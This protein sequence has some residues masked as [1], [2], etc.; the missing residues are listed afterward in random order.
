MLATQTPGGSTEDELTEMLV[1]RGVAGIIFV[2]G[3]HADTTADMQRYEQLRGQGVP[4]RPR[5]RLL[6]EG[7]GARSSPPT[8]GRRCA[9]PSR[10]WC[11]WATRRIGLALGP[12]RFVP[13][14]RKIEGFLRT[15][16]EQLGLTRGA[17]GAGWSSTPSTR[18]RAARPP[19]PR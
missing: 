11:R 16:Q 10:T 1:D 8:T 17:G 5:Q 6:A 12:K 13:V 15:M 3:L 2:S 19:P 4:V 9:W 14:Q 18:W 7:A